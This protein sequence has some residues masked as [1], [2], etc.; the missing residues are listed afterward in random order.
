MEFYIYQKVS[1]VRMIGWNSLGLFQNCKWSH[2]QWCSLRGELLWGAIRNSRW[3]FNLILAVTCLTCSPELLHIKLPGFPEKILEMF[4]R[5]LV[6]FRTDLKFK[7]AALVS[8]WRKHLWF[9]SPELLHAKSPY[10]K[11]HYGS[12]NSF[13]E[14]ENVSTIQ[15]LWGSEVNS[16]MTKSTCIILL[17]IH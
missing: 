8:D 15:W 10:F 17:E 16:K 12:S 1:R 9:F 5:S 6:S 13:G 11:F 14:V 7:V 2:Y 4:L 3:P